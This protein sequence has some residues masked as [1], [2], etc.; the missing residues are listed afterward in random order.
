MPS[1]VFIVANDTAPSRLSDGRKKGQRQTLPFQPGSPAHSPFLEGESGRN[2]NHA[3]GDRC[4]GDL[5]HA[6][7]WDTR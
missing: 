7:I 2:L 5:P 6:R 4:G 3:T 1:F